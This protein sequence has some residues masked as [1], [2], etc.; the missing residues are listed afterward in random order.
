MGRVREFYRPTGPVRP[1]TLIVRDPASGTMFAAR[2]AGRKIQAQETGTSCREQFVANRSLWDKYCHYQFTAIDSQHVPGAAACRLVISTFAPTRRET[3]DSRAQHRAGAAGEAG[4]PDE[5]RSSRLI[6]SRCRAGV[7]ATARQEN[8]TMSHRR[9]GWSPTG[10]TSP[11]SRI[12]IGTSDAEGRR[13]SS[14]A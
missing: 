13:I 5:T 2:P 11:G 7:N 10:W 8:C 14:A 9:A 6:C 3:E 1:S 4:A 12:A